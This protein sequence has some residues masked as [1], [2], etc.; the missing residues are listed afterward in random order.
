MK[1]R[2]KLVEV[3][4]EVELFNN[5]T[6]D[7]VYTWAK[8]IQHNVTHGW[9]DS[10]NPI[11]KIPTLDKDMICSLGD[12]LI[13]EPFSID[14]RKLCPCKPDIFEKTYELYE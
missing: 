5:H 4:V 14:W 12:Y 1:Y 6:K 3:V 10:G 7:R 11:L 8:S 13:V 9:D 2:K